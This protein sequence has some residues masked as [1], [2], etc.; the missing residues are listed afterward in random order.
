METILSISNFIF[1]LL[2]SFSSSLSLS[3]L[4]FLFTISPSPSS[5][6]IFILPPLS[7]PLF[8]LVLLSP[9]VHS[10][11]QPGIPTLIILDE[12]G[13]VIT[14]QGRGAVTS[15]PEG[16]VSHTHHVVFSELTLYGTCDTLPLS[17]QEFPWHPKPVNELTGGTAAEINDVPCLIWFTGL[18]CVWGYSPPSILLSLFYL[19]PSLLPSLS[20]LHHL[21]PSTTALPPSLS[22]LHHSLPPS[23]L[24]LSLLH[25]SLHQLSLSITSLPPSLSITSLPP[26]LSFTSLPPS[27]LSLHHS[28]SSITSLPPSLSFT[29]LSPSLSF[30]HHLSP[31]V[32]LLHLSPSITSLPPSP[33]SLH[34]SPSDGEPENMEEAKA[35]LYPIAEEYIANHKG[36]E[37]ENEIRFFYSGDNDD[38]D[39][40]QSLRKFAHLPSTNPLLAIVDIPSQKVS[41]GL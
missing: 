36:K 30:L 14:S 19:S 27:P 38:D 23:T 6:P 41:I 3:L 40:V 12:E 15:D 8:I 33:L 26:S 2:F 34:H 37:Q 35:V 4:L 7:F 32:T 39:I 24:S 1:V 13:N 29:S 28:P 21:S 9:V 11:L 10:A 5:F 22:S 31:S 20:S 25:H 16:K 17:L 18:C